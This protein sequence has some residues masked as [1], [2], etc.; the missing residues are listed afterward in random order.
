MLGIALIYSPFI[1][2]CFEY[3]RI[4]VNFVMVNGSINLF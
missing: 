2:I 1:A 4:F 3:F